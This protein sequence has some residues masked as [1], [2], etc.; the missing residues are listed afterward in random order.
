MYRVN[1]FC[2]FL[3]SFAPLQLAEDWDNVGLLIGDREAP[4]SSVMTCLTVTPA[5]VD[6]AVAHRA[7][8]IVTHHPMPF[9]PIKKITSDTTVGQILLKLIKNEIAVYSPHTAFDS[10]SF[11]INQQIAEKLGCQSISPLKPEIEDHQVGTGRMGQLNDAVSLTEFANRVK[12]SF[13]TDHV[14]L[15]GNEDQMI[16]RVAVA[17]G[18][19]GQFL[20]DAATLNCDAFVT[21]ETS[22]HTCLEAEALGVAMI[23][24]GHYASERFAL[25]GLAQLLKSEFD[26]ANIWASSTE[27][28]PLIWY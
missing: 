1:D 20:E 3:A 27:K 13:S 7:N 5:T 25:E 18:S 28:T 21:G 11:G 4:A 22:F 26:Q 16:R 14:Q 8:L 9:R 10:S 12:H 2:D 24:T 23:L 6:E 15:V 17:C 19:A